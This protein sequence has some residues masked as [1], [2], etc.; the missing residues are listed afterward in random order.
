MDPWSAARRKEFLY[1]R[2]D[3]WFVND[4]A[5]GFYLRGQKSYQFLNF[6]VSQL[7][8]RVLQDCHR[9]SDWVDTVEMSSYYYFKIH[10]AAISKVLL[11]TGR[12]VMK[13]CC[14]SESTS[15]RRQEPCS[16]CCFL[17]GG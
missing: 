2:T 6:S 9:A 5:A 17:S 3:I 12:V 16:Q 7:K 4:G 10:V 8:V 13:R 15:W 1:L 11:K 14:R